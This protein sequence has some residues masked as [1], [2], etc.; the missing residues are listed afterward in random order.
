MANKF[1]ANEEKWEIIGPRFLG[2]LERK[3]EELSFSV[4]ETL[5]ASQVS[6]KEDCRESLTKELW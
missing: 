3:G 5:L 1:S 4:G 2:E 6:N